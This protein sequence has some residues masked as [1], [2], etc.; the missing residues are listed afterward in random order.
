MSIKEIIVILILL[1]FMQII[2]RKQ[3]KKIRNLQK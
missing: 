3:V 1:S 2:F